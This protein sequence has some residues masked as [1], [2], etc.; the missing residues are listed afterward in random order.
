MTSATR[1]LSTD[2]GL[3]LSAWA[4]TARRESPGQRI[5]L[6]AVEIDPGGPGSH[7]PGG[8]KEAR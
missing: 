3:G 1:S 8:G 4:Q 5:R 6:R 7:L 2:F